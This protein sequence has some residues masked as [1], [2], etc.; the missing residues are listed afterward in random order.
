VSP[1][2]RAVV[3]FTLAFTLTVVA[4]NGVAS[5]ARGEYRMAADRA[6]HI[7]GAALGAMWGYDRARRSK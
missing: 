1:F 4:F 6:A 3:G 5:A 2:N 7:A